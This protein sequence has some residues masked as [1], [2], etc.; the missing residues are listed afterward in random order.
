MRALL[1]VVAALGCGNKKT[2]E[3]APPSADSMPVEIAA[4][5]P[6]NAVQAW[7]G[8]HLTRMPLRDLMDAEPVV[9]DVKGES[10]KGFDGTKEYPL[11]FSITAPC[12]AGFDQART[13]GQMAGNT[14]THSKQFLI[15]DGMLI[16]GEGA[17]GMR[18]GKTAV[19]CQFGV[20]TLVTLDDKGVCKSWENVTGWTSK[21]VPCEWSTTEDGR[22]QLVVDGITKLVADG[23]LL[24]D[25]GFVSQLRRGLHTQHTSYEAA[26][27]GLQPKPPQ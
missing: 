17:V 20:N 6:R 23:D 15:K 22:E 25:D 2:G 11:G 12:T 9:L 4:W 26:K 14:L 18:K 7:Q 3:P 19:V 24:M 1:V 8:A 10:A 21:T 27:L 13:E 16:A 5:M